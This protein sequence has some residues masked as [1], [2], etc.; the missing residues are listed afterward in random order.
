MN[1]TLDPIELCHAR[2][3]LPGPQIRI[4]C[5]DFGANQSQCQ[6]DCVI[7]L[8]ATNI[9]NRSVAVAKQLKQN[10]MQF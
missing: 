2:A 4:E 8:T 1:A 5:L 9:D 7:A 10:R 3:E 6:P